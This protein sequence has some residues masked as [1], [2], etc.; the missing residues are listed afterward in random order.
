MRKLVSLQKIKNLIPIDWADRIEIAE[1]QW[2]QVIVWKNKFKIWDYCIFFEIDSLIP[3]TDSR[4]SF[5]EKSCSIKKVIIEETPGKI[6]EY[7]GYRLKTMKMRGVISQWL[8]MPLEEFPE[9]MEF[10]E[11]SISREVLNS[12]DVWNTE[13]AENL[14]AKYLNN[15]EWFDL[16]NL[17]K[18][19]K[20]ELQIPEELKGIVKWNFPSD[21]PITD[22]TR[23]QNLLEYFNEY[24][25]VLFFA[26]EKL[27]WTSTTYRKIDWEL[28]VCWKNRE[29][30]KESDNLFWKLRENLW[31]DKK[32]FNWYSIQGETFGAKIQWNP[33]KIPDKRFYIHSVWDIKNKRYL[34][35]KEYFDF[36]ESY[37]LISAPVRYENIS[38]KGKSIND[39]IELTNIN[40]LINDSRKIEG[41]VFRPYQ[42]IRDKKWNRVS[43]KVINPDY[44]IETDT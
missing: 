38:I 35:Y 32:D 44:L 41:L 37:W 26:T 28:S 33:L 39:L 27:D 22:E 30:R 23:I 5:L 7:E 34:S 42:E 36:I 12:C 25:D 8:V 43:F 17:F 14:H 29:F 9:V 13:D 10:I 3:L 20:Y 24:E 11:Y 15:I 31:L 40:S 18:V 21:T 4:F 6:N 2:W 16:T 1:I 19:V